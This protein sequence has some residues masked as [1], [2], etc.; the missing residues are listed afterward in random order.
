[1]D[2]WSE[3][4]DGGEKRGAKRGDWEGEWIF[5]SRTWKGLKE[6]AIPAWL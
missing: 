1:M 5:E 2:S 4:N 3:G 6:V